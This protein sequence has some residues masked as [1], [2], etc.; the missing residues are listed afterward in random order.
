MMG[1][2]TAPT[3]IKIEL[4][5]SI[6]LI[7]SQAW[8][9]LS[10]DNP[11]M[12]HQFLAALEHS[13][14]VGVGTGW[15]PSHLVAFKEARLIAIMPLY[16][17]DNSDGEYVF[18]WAW[19]DAYH[20]YGVPYYP[21]L[22]TATPFTPATG[23]RLC[24]APGIDRHRLISA[25]IA[26]LRKRI[27]EGPYSSWHLLFPDQNELH[28]FSD[29]ELMPRLGCQFH[30]SNLEYR[31]FD[32]FLQRFSSRKRK[33]LKRER[34]RVLEQGISLQ[35]FTGKQ[36][37]PRQL[38]IFYDFYQATYLKRGRPGYLTLPFFQQILET[39]P[40]QLVLVMAYRDE[41]PLAGALS[42]RDKNTLYGRYWGCFEEFECLHFE[43]CYYQGIEFCIQQGLQR[44]DPGAQGEHKISRG[45]EPVLTYSL[46]WIGDPGFR[47]AI[48]HY[49]KREREE[50][51]AYLNRAR[52]LLPFKTENPD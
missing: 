29:T 21:K 31:N 50:I 18:D 40:E 46:H 19:A 4:L 33:S 10:G 22:L 5:D 15:T 32:Q 44:F 51:R 39:M 16:I 24:T 9:R 49:L 7:P 25:I 28:E 6:D 42:F 52:A 20:R 27:D 36:I 41:T 30:W 45:F 26:E 48:E 47:Q 14:S 3:A 37:T 35:T 34:R 13:N 43:A 23:P 8:N 38:E 11:F 1:I 12:R 2:K 17:K